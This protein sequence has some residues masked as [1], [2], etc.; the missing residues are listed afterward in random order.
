[1]LSSP[2]L[3]VAISTLHF[4]THRVPALFLTV[5][6]KL[7]KYH[8]QYMQSAFKVYRQVELNKICK[9]YMKLI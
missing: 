4:Q 6:V 5:D 2:C 9:C 1:M 8:T 7:T 3:N